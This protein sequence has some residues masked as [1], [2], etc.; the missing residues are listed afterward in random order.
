MT[1]LVEDKEIVVPGQ[2]LAEGDSFKPK[3][4][5]YRSGN[6]L[7]SMAVGV[8]NLRKNELSVTPFSGKYY[9]KVGDTVIGVVE[10]ALLT[11]WIVQIGGPYK[12]V[13]LASNATNRFDPI[14][15][16]SM[17]IFAPG[18]LLLAEIISFDR[19]KDPQLTVK[20]RNLQKLVG[21]RV[22]DIQPNLI[23]R[24]IGRKGSMLSI[25]TKYTNTKMIVGQNGR[26][27]IKGDSLENELLALEAI[28][29]IERESHVDGLTA[30]IEE[31]LKENSIRSE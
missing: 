31:M 15:D 2:V 5:V 22:V 7:L 1:L 30:R 20:K 24:V 13:L 3:R 28:K 9:P 25:I 16:D 23:R 18:D 26:V 11:S 12:A 14:K 6:K 4:G 19:T 8:C 21:G 29:K 10:E 17:K 27:W